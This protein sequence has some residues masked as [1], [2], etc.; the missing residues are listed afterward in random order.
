MI[1]LSKIAAKVLKGLPDRAQDVLLRRFG[2]GKNE[3]PETLEAIGADYKIT[4]ERVRQIEA[5]A[6][7]RIRSQFGEEL[8]EVYGHLNTEITKYGGVVREEDFLKSFGNQKNANYCSLFLNLGEDFIRL[9]EDDEFHHRWTNNLERANNVHAA[10]M[11]VRKSITPK[12]LLTQ[13]E[14]ISRFLNNIT[15]DV[16]RVQAVSILGIARK[17]SCNGIGEWGLTSSSQVR[18]R[19]VR[20]LAGLVLRKHGE[21]MHFT[22]IAKSIQS[23][24]GEKAHVQTVHNELIKDSQFV[25]VGR[26]LYALTSM[27]Y[28]AGVVSDVIGQILKEKGPM[29][30]EAIIQEVMKERYVKESTIAINLQNKKLFRKTDEGHFTVV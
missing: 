10:L 2:L 25:L 3:E 8:N 20:D 22:Q 28:R 4:R 30:R 5:A 24:L 26:G 14:V 21:P 17:I 12:D 13:D 11:A 7:T 1:Q 27:G 16:P 29:H 18:P 9:R 23:V 15:G 6:L 19:G